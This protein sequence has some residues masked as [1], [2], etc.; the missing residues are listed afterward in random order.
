[1]LCV[2][3]YSRQHHSRSERNKTLRPS[4]NDALDTSFAFQTCHT[5]VSVLLPRI[6][7]NRKAHG[8]PKCDRNDV[9]AGVRQQFDGIY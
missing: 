5:E 1:M 4:R 8:E 2:W 7:T 3:R 6:A 9:V